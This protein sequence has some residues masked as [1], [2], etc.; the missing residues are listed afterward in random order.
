MSPTAIEL[1][2]SVTV[3]VA[4]RFASALRLSVLIPSEPV[5]LL[6]EQDSMLISAR[7]SVTPRDDTAEFVTHVPAKPAT[8]VEVPAGKET[9]LIVEDE[10]LLRDLA[11]AILTGCGYEVLEAGTGAEAF[12]DSIPG[13]PE[14][15][16]GDSLPDVLVL[17]SLTKTWA[18]AG[19]RVG[20]ALGA[21]EVLARLSRSAWRA[22]V[23][24]RRRWL[25]ARCQPIWT[26]AQ[27]WG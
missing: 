20:Y 18:L 14:S 26:C 6:S 22:A 5:M 12:A 27:M 9:I 3:T 17:R 11:N 23:R 25:K 8:E 1:D 13:E 4:T 19:L 10:P 24:S 7:F 21:P 2:A 15:L 16:A